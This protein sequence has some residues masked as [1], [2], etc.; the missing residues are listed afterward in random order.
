[1]I[2]TSDDGT[3]E[4]ADDDVAYLRLM[5]K[6]FDPAEHPAAHSSVYG[7]HPTPTPAIPGCRA[8]EPA[9]SWPPLPA[10]SSP[11]PR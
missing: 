7:R 1:M 8:A 6:P 11:L 3:K 2:H 10:P 9:C 4:T 5:L